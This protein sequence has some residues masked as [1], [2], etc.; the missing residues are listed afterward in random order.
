MYFWSNIVWTCFSG[1]IPNW[2]KDRI[3][4]AIN[5]WVDLLEVYWWIYT[6]S[7]SSREIAMRVWRRHPNWNS[8]QRATKTQLVIIGRIRVA[9]GRMGTNGGGRNLEIESS[10]ERG[11]KVAGVCAV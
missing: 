8:T 5:Y 2:H 1:A 10:I 7:S 4:M 9:I 3:P 11:D 6:I